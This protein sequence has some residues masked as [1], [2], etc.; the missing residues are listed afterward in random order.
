MSESTG[1]RRVCLV[2][3]G[4]I[5][6]SPMAA[7]VLGRMVEE[8]G[9]GGRVEVGS[10]GTGPW[11]VGEDPDPRSVR[12]LE[13]RGYPPPAATARQFRP[14]WFAKEDLILALDSGHASELRAMAPDAAAATRIRLL[15]SFDPGVRGE[16]DV[17]DPYYSGQAAFDRCLAVI[18]PACRGVVEM[19]R[20]ELG[21]G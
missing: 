4:N 1:T 7:V 18:E 17:P 9:L 15:R 6:R 3:S 14:S 5:C 20:R 11:H 19:L 8:A 10:A 2:C 12:A 21:E 13:R 16:L